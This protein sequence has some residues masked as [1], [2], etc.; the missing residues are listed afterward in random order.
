MIFSQ[1]KSFWIKNI[2]I[3][4]D[5]II[6]YFDVFVPLLLENNP[7][8]VIQLHGGTQSKDALYDN[9]AGASKYWK[10]VAEKNNFLLI[11]PNG[12]DTKTGN[13]KEG[14][15]NWND[16]R[17]HSKEIQADDVG[18]ISKII[19]WS[20]ANYKV[21]DKKV[22]VTGVS[23]GGLMCYRLALEIPN[24]ITAIAVFNANLYK[25]SECKNTNIPIP[26]MIVNG[27][28][29]KFMPFYGGK[30]K[31]KNEDALSSQETLIFWIKNNFQGSYTPKI[32]IT[33]LGKT[34]KKTITYTI[35][36]PENYKFQIRYYEI[37]NGGHTMP[38]MK[39]VLPK[40]IQRMVGKQNQEVEGA[41]IAWNFFK[42]ISK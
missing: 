19:D 40:F 41:E 38:G 16:C 36:E 42:E 3:E 15:L 32:E 37:G 7:A 34:S 23:N 31:F 33:K 30:T 10:E 27:V 8:L 1:E 28:K 22:F 6:R 17:N 4:H 13:A 12:I 5:G 21:N 2:E 35:Y 39:Y 20:I 25:E 18:F 9:H 11:V 14:N 24:K 26:V 29:D